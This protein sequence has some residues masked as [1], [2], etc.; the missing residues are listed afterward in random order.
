VDLKTRVG[1]VRGLQSTQD[2]H[3][4]LDRKR[5]LVHAVDWRKN[6]DQGIILRIGIVPKAVLVN[7]LRSVHVHP[8]A[9]CVSLSTLDLT[10]RKRKP[11]AGGHPSHVLLGARR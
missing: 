1:S 4:P 8:S 10:F 9:H 3:L 2:L 6:G 11:C 5:S 7:A